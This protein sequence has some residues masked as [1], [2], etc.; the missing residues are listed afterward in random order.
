MLGKAARRIVDVIVILFALYAFVFVPLGSK[1]ALGHLRAILSTPAASD[2]GREAEGALRRLWR[3]LSGPRDA[4]PANAS[5]R[6]EP[7]PG[8]SDP[9]TPD[10]SLAY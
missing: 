4:A 2:A 7:P 10:A 5:I 8:A 1:T 3:S 9:D 6:A